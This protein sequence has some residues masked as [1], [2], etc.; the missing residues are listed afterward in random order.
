MERT[1]LITRIVVLATALGINIVD[2]SK[3]FRKSVYGIYNLSWLKKKKLRHVLDNEFFIWSWAMATYYGAVHY[4]SQGMT[5]EASLYK[6][7]FEDYFLVV[8]KAQNSFEIF[9]FW[10]QYIDEVASISEEN[11]QGTKDYNERILEKLTNMFSLK[12]LKYIHRNIV[13]L[14][15][16]ALNE[17][18]G[19]HVIAV[20]R[21]LEFV[22]YQIVDVINH[23]F[24]EADESSVE[25]AFEAVRNKEPVK[26]LITKW[27]AR[28]V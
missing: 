5:E 10:K 18:W 11:Y 24:T 3:S 19:E 9:D 16:P 1:H 15:T 2:S 27:Q 25:V 13:E 12:T 23:Y 26:S 7:I 21:D 20:Q 4:L 6:S 8:P 14:D 22:V 17:T 28:Y